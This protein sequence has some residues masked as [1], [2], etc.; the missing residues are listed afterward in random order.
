[1]EVV[2]YMFFKRIL[3]VFAALA[4]IFTLCACGTTP[5]TSDELDEIPVVSSE[6]E[7]EPEPELA[8]NNLTGEKN[9][10]LDATGKK[11]VAVMVNNAGVAQR[12][13]S[14][15]DK[16]DVVFETEVEGG[17]TRLIALFSDPSNLSAVGTIRS[18]RV[19]FADIACGMDAILFYHGIDPTY[20]ASHLK[21][22]PMNSF[23]VDAKTYGYRDRSNGLAYEHTLYT[24]GEKID[25]VISDKK[26]NYASSRGPWLTFNSS[27]E[28]IIPAG[29]ATNI[30]A[31]FSTAST[32]KFLYNT[33]LKKYA[34]ANKNGTAYTDLSS[35]NQE[36][37]TNI[38]IL[39]TTISYYPDGKHRKVDLSSGTGYYATVGGFEE[40]NWKK[41]SS[42]DNFS[43]TK[44]DG[45][46]LTV[47]QGNSYVCIMGGTGSVSFE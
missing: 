30:T 44:A 19:P 3:S 9:L 37:F 42:T 8:I 11:P 5:P 2:I 35:G 36:L 43:F 39:K 28:P 38:F 13:Q 34:R 26:F 6:P 22:L 40:I 7:P 25:K 32:T 18:L 15:L 29:V 10:P 16:A 41:G 23:V 12:V 46:P 21:T 33:E 20:C 1:M 45:S 17:I 31:K 27:E 24:T 14:G 4:I 47:N